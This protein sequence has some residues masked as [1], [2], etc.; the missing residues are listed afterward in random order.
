M[1]RRKGTILNMAGEDQKQETQSHSSKEQLGS[2]R[3]SS[4]SRRA[5]VRMTHDDAE[6]RALI[7]ATKLSTDPNF[8]EKKKAKREKK[9]K[10]SAEKSLMCNE[11]GNVY[12]PQNQKEPEGSIA[13][14][15]PEKLKKKMK[16]KKK[17]KVQCDETLRFILLRSAL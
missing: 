7:L 3:S 17:R 16:K 10:K 15:Q 5:P 8:E 9:K 14:K 6:T 2:L 1:R 12:E 11:D 4:R 13:E